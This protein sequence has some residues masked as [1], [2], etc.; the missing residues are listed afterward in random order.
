MPKT[1]LSAQDEKLISPLFRPY[2]HCSRER[3]IQYHRGALSDEGCIISGPWGGGG[4][5]GLRLTAS[6]DVI[7]VDRNRWRGGFLSM[8][9][10]PR[11]NTDCF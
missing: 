3:L 2:A 5:L 4:G 9:E 7:W 1:Q 10:A 6:R 11:G 8:S